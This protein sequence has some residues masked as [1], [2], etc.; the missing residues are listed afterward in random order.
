MKTNY[1]LFRDY[2]S[3]LGRYIQSDPIG[4]SGGLNSYA[5]AGQNSLS[6]FD[7]NGL[8]QC[9]LKFYLNKGNFDGILTCISDIDNSML[10]L[11][12]AAGNNIGIKCKNNPRIECQRLSEIGPLPAGYW[13]IDHQKVTDKTK[14]ANGIV[15]DAFKETKTYGRKYFR[16]HHCE[17]AF[18]PSVK[19]PP[20]S[21]GCVT[22]NKKEMEQL[23]EFLLRDFNQYK[24]M[25]NQENST[26]NILYVDDILG[27][28]P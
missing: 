17:N 3:S 27:V 25:K 8:A 9:T 23:K 18:G 19:T 13:K 6:Y 16:I 7:I 5:Y 12:A 26:I 15:L 2:N 24:D 28:K 21:A 20:C 10:Q 22:L 1:N 14:N 11:R 4:L